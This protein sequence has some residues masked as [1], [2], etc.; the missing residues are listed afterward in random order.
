MTPRFE[1]D[2]EDFRRWVHLPH[3]AIDRF[4]DPY[5]F[6]YR[7]D[8]KCSDE[9]TIEATGV[10]ERISGND[11][12]ALNKEDDNAIR[13][14]LSSVQCLEMGPNIGATH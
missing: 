2:G 13:R 5:Q 7:Y 11:S 4:E 12:P 1:G 3:P 10:L 14:I 6:V 9:W 8:F